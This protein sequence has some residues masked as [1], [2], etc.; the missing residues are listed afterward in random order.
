M[1]SNEDLYRE[2][3]E[4]EAQD[5]ARFDQRYRMKPIRGVARKEPDPLK[6]MKRYREEILPVLEARR[7]VAAGEG[8]TGNPIKDAW[9]RITGKDKVPEM[10]KEDVIEPSKGLV[11]DGPTIEEVQKIISENP[12][13]FRDLA[14]AAPEVRPVAAERK[15]P[16]HYHHD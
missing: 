4:Q 9:L 16:S 2:L 8:P 5:D 13:K 10:A 6:A 7:R 12:D 15:P 11:I 1:P 3:E 14:K